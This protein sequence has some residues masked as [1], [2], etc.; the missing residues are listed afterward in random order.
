MEYALKAAGYLTKGS[1]EKR[2]AKP[3][4][5][6]FAKQVRAVIERSADPDLA[7]AVAYILKYPPKKQVVIDDKL[8]WDATPPNS[9]SQAERVIIYVRRIRNNLFHGGKF[10]GH[11]FAPERSGKLMRYGLTILKACRDAEPQVKE[12]Y[13]N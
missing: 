6:R 11:W 13:Y 4:W 8:A 7:E 9:G 3:D 12:A 5:D 10:N 1:G 2:D